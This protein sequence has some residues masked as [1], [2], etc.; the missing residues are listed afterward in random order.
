M[1]QIKQQLHKN[2]WA[3]WTGH[4]VGMAISFF[5]VPYITSVLGGA[6]YGVWVIVFQTISY[7]VLF[8]F[9]LEQALVRFLSK[10]LSARDFAR[11][12]RTLST[13]LGLYLVLGSAI[14]VGVWLTATFLFDYVKVGDPAMLQEGKS[15]LKIIG[16]YLGMRFYL[17]P[18]G[19]SLGGFQRFDIARVLSIAEDVLR[20]GLMVWL[21]ANG[22]GLVALAWTVVALSTLRYGTAYVILKRIHPEIAVSPRGFD[23]ATAKDLLGYSKIM[24]GIT[25]GWLVVFNTDS[26]LLGLLASSAAAGVYAPG[27]ALVLHT[28]MIINAVGGPLTAAVSH[29][30]ARN[31]ME[32]VQRLYAR[33]IKYCSYVSFFVSVG[34][35]VYARPFVALWLEPEFAGAA[36][37][38]RVLAVS[39]AFFAPQI[40]GNAVLFGTDNHSHLL[41][42]L[43]LEATAKI[44]LSLILIGP[45]GLIGM[46][47]A[48]AIPQ[49]LLYVT[50]YPVL[51]ARVL[52]VTPASIVLSSLRSGLTAMM[53]GLPVMLIMRFLMAPNSWA[54][55]FTNV[56]AASAVTL[57][58]GWFV[59]EEGDREKVR[60]W[61]HVRPQSR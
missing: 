58:A 50:L 11:I 21:L 29:L 5:F 44:A 46:A 28:R 43:V 23:R 25:L 27:A 18:Y 17:M 55:L 19:G 48:A 33:G 38:M 57:L 8:D 16:L 40:L 3:S 45:Y 41:R 22:Y 1:D 49:F 60:I 37:V 39:G 51:L 53:I 59:L 52:N 7:F 4:F 20:A 6:R 14:I 26:V 56:I 61:L 15:A 12:N 47:W 36:E 32:S 10:Y 30:E 34:V 2:I 54:G 9:G 42:V 31:D 13:T 24:F 35:I